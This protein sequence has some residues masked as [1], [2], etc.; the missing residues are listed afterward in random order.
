M[1]FPC[2]VLYVK[3]NNVDFYPFLV[4]AQN[5]DEALGIA[6]RIGYKCLPDGYQQ[7]VKVGN[8]EAITPE[9]ACIRK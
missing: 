5:K 9:A 3:D 4:E 2:T 6:T 8:T 1:R 7:H